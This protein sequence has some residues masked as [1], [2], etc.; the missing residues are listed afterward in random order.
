[1]WTD[2]SSS[3][4]WTDDQ[5]IAHLY[6]VGPEGAHLSAC[7]ECWPRFEAIEE[8]RKSMLAH[9]ERTDEVSADFLAAQ[10]RAIRAR[11]DEKHGWLRVQHWLRH[12]GDWLREKSSLISPVP[13]IRT[14]GQAQ[15]LEVSMPEEQVAVSLET[16][17]MPVEQLAESPETQPAG[18][19][20]A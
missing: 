6:G 7:A 17:S 15:R 9:N 13:V 10:H 2:K 12:L 11:M 4:H 3:E 5:V 19:E 18:L 16:V 14:D 8:R 1:M 20:T